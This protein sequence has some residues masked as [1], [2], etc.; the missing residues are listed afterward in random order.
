MAETKRAWS[1]PQMFGAALAAI[2]LWS[3]I[4]FSWFGFGFGWT[5]QGG[6]E[7]MRVNAVT[8][9][10]ASICVAQARTG[11]NSEVSLKEFAALSSWKQRE[12]VEKARWATMPGS[13][14]A[15]RSVAEL[16]ATKLRET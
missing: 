15:A 13:D 12:F 2:V 1:P 7:K 5:T 8:E 10:L 6:A 9:S 4:G 16:C 14:S 11:S 3:A